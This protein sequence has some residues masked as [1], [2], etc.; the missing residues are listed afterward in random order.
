MSK[1]L[2]PRVP[3]G[4]SCGALYITDDA[5]A[6]LEAIVEAADVLITRYEEG[7]KTHCATGHGPDRACNC[8][9]SDARNVYDA[10]RKAVGK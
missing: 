7:C 5:A 4:C 3:C 10:A 9:W 1:P 8:G 6:K 2:V